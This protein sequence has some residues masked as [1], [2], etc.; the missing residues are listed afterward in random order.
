MNP[1]VS[2]SNSSRA[3]VKVEEPDP[4]KIYTAQS[5]AYW[6]GRF[7]SLQ[8]RFRSETLT[9]ENL[10]TLVQAHA[11]H[12]LVSVVRPSLASSATTSCIAPPPPPPPSGLD[13]TRRAVTNKFM[14]VGSNK[15]LPQRLPQLRHQER[16]PTPQPQRQSQQQ[17]QQPNPSA[18]SSAVPKTSCAPAT[19]TATATATTTTTTTT[20]TAT[21]SSKSDS[22]A[23]AA[24]MNEDER[25]RRVFRHLDAQCATSEARTSLQ[26]W[27]ETY[28][29][30]TGK[31]NLLPEGGSMREKLTR[32]RTWV[33]RLLSGSGS[34]RVRSGGWEPAW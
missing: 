18:K 9:P 6:T 25:C 12:S 33:G 21:S 27:Q 5:S 7:M 20:A 4:Y 16:S 34:G 26:Q 17:Q 32:E 3:F 15:T 11:D 28:A 22:P 23:A 19:A 2:S 13:F 8:D 14:I 30:Q 10:A 24:L 1:P 29:R 31:E